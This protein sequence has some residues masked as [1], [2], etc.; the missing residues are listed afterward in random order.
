MAWQQPKTDWV[1]N[2]KSPVGEDFNR[3]EGNIDFLKADIET[4]KGVIVDAMNDVGMEADI[5]DTHADLAQKI[6][7]LPGMFLKS[8]QRGVVELA[9]QNEHDITINPVNIN[10]TVATLQVMPTSMS[11]L[12]HQFAANIIIKNSTTISIS[13]PGE[14]LYGTY[15]W[16][17]IEFYPDMVK[18]LQVLQG[19]GPHTIQAVNPAKTI[20]FHTNRG[21]GVGTDQAGWLLG[22]AHLSSPT[23][24]VTAGRSASMSYIYVIEFY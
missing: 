14:G 2:P 22:Y 13:N 7:Q 24:V 20:I 1:I 11:T 12:I 9:K 8:V 15:A 17:V 4:K 6:S 10:T 21:S 3:I 16:Q 5:T 23:Q 19:A 18:S